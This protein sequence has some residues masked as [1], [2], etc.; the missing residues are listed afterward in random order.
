MSKLYCVFLFLGLAVSLRHVRALSQEEIAAIKTGL[1]PLIAECG[2][3][4][5]VDE[6][7]F[8]KAKESGKLESLDPCLFACIGKKMGMIN[9]KGEFDVEKSSE[10]V[11]KFVKNEDEL[12]KILEVI[13][14]CASVNDEAVSDDKGCDR[15]V[16]LH[17]C[18]EPYRD[19]IYSTILKAKWILMKFCTD[20]EHSLEEHIGY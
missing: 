9:D 11:K 15:A 19:Q 18:M 8:K 7:D 10:T 14:K 6:A 5:G 3:E 20:A 17:K 12:K 13:E 1:R 4:F 2:K 16:L